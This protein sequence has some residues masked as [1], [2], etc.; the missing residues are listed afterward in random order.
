MAFLLGVEE[1]S[2]TTFGMTIFIEL[3]HRA[4]ANKV[5]IPN[6]VRDPSSLSRPNKFALSEQSEA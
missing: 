3:S 6:V 5:V 1:R 4:N 2:L